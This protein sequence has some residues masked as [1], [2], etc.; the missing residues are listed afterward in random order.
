MRTELSDGSGA[1]HLGDHRI[2]NDCGEPATAMLGSHRDRH[3]AGAT[4]HVHPNLPDGDSGLFRDPEVHIGVFERGSQPALVLR[5]CDRTPGD[6]EAHRIRVVAPFE[7]P[8]RVLAGRRT[9]HHAARGIL[10]VSQRTRS[11]H[12]STSSVTTS[13]IT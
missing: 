5:G 4:I 1:A 12:S 11:S 10:G 13:W 3:K 8:T 9:Q 6:A 7:K 2:E